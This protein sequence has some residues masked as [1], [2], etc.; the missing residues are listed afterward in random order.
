MQAI[1]A[2]GK[3][4][5]MILI[6]GRALAIGWEKEHLD[7]I[8]DGWFLGQ[9]S[10]TAL[11][12]TIFGENN[13]GGKL[14]VTYSRNVGQLPNFYNILPSGRGRR[15]FGSSPELLYPFGFGLSYTTF[16][17]SDYSLSK[18]E[19]TAN[20]T[21]ILSVNVTNTGKREGDEVVQMYVHKKYC[22]LIQPNLKLRGFKRVTVKPGQTVTVK[23]P[24][25]REDLQIWKNGGWVVEPGEYEIL[26][27]TSAVSKKLKKLILNVK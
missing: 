2:T 14:P 22:S 26:V 21:A 16:K 15:L 25:R 3:P 23:L 1:K 19:M 12:K 5:I 13:P 6:H 17:L 24:I 7:A 4:V 18:K 8:L 20:D 27:G 11:A 10:G 9:E